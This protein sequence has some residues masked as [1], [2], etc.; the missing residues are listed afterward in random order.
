MRQTKI[1]CV[2]MRGGTS[3]GAYF[4]A[5]DLP[6]DVETRDKVLL[7]V[8]GSPDARQ[9][10]GMG[11]ADPL[12][13]KVAIISRS[14]RPDAD[15]D[16]LF[17]QVVVN[18]ARV[19]TSPT[20]GNI[21]AGVGPFAIDEGLIEAK[22]G[23]T[24]VR[25]FMVNTASLCTAKI[26]GVPGTSAPIILHFLE[27]EG[28]SCGSLLPSGHVKDT[29][30]GVE[31]TMADNGMPVVLMRAADVGATGDEAPKELEAKKDVKAKIESIR[32]KCGPIMN[33]GD[34]ANK[35]V[36]KMTL[37]SPPKEGGAVST[38]TFI[39]HKC[40]DAIGVLGAVTVATGC[41]LPGSVGEG[42][43]IIS[44]GKTKTISI[45]HPTGEFTVQLETAEENGQIK[46]LSAGL[47]RTARRL[48]EGSVLVPGAIW[49]GRQAVLKH[50]AE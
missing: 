41:V 43:A 7:A 39:P 29:I 16:Y 3:K 15:I 10:D 11:G 18:E 46:V 44:E 8:M 25:I 13:S 9:I 50:V 23:E 30:D 40:H 28:S 24:P 48:F 42:I 5:A 17:A 35:V 1:P 32:L 45:E 4:H 27:T 36:P 49:Q 31:V 26:S 14:K 12:T 34:V 20:C 33:L 37:I 2:W 6:D 21:L 19:D 47:L 38:R 22:D